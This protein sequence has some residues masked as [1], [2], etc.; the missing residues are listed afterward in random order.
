[1]RERRVLVKTFAAGYQRARKKEKSGRLKAFTEMTGYHRSYAA[2]LLRHEGRRIRWGKKV[3][4][5]EVGKEIRRR[6]AKKYNQA[7]LEPLKRLWQMLDYLCGK[8]LAAILPE[9]VPRLERDGELKVAPEVRKRLLQISV[10]TIDRL[11]A[12]ERRKLRLK[13]RSRTKPGT[14]IKYQIPIKRF[15]DWQEDWPEGIICKLSMSRTS[16]VA[17][18]RIGP[19]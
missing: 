16:A 13:G 1:M 19:S 8:R 11:L 2:S 9:V 4:V 5:A 18:R 7:V 17:G 14:L 12:G 3:V 6:R 10:A 15:S